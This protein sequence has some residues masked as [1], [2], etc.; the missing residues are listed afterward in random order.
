MIYKYQEMRENRLSEND[1]MNFDD[2]KV[3]LKVNLY[4]E[5]Y[6]EVIFWP[7]INN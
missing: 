1:I 7:E 5:C 6:P 2:R 3:A 4:S